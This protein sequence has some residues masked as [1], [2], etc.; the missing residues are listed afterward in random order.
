MT[1]E[2]NTPEPSLM[3]VFLIGS[4]MSYENGS[5]KSLLTINI[6]VSRSA[7][8]QIHLS[9]STVTAPVIAWLDE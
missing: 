9:G 2:N 7:L 1:V 3:K 8:G 5:D 4:K 6:R